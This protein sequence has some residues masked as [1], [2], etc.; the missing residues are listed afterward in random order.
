MKKKLY[1]YELVVLDKHEDDARRNLR[2]YFRE[3]T[4]KEQNQMR[5][6]SKME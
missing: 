2:H 1:E 5:L 6:L 3:E 4:A